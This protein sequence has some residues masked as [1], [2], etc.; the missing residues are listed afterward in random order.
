MYG[1][2]SAATLANYCDFQVYSN[3]LGT[4]YTLYFKQVAQYIWYDFTVSALSPNGDGVIYAAS[5]LTSTAPSGG[6]ITISSVFTNTNMNLQDIAG[7]LN[8]SGSVINFGTNTTGTQ[9]YLNDIATAAWKLDTGGFQLTMAIGTVG[10]AYT[11]KFQFRTN[12]F[13]YQS[14]GASSW[15]ALSDQKVKE[16]IIIAD[17]DICYDILKKI[18]L[19]RFNY[20]SNL[21]NT[22]DYYDRT[23]L[24]WIAQDVQKVLPKSVIIEK[25]DTIGNYLSLN[26]DQIYASMYGAI[27]KIIEKVEILEKQQSLKGKGTILS[28]TNSIVINVSGIVSE[29]PIIQ[30]TPIFNGELRILN[31]SMFE[32][33]SFT[34]YGNPGDF[35]WSINS[36]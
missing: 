1:F 35:F 24:G 18:P 19:K 16:N 4:V 5:A 11:N 7:T 25:D 22:S 34:V 30:I 14:G 20:N 21:I 29:M 32:N 10:G 12:G 27:Q 6:S 33:G 36:I 26:V 3:A 31:V 8:Y 13:G 15:L 17:L 23:R 2:T 28:D 9:L